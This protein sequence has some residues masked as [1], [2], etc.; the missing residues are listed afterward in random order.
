MNPIDHSYE[1]KQVAELKGEGIKY[2]CID[3]VSMVSEQM[4]NVIAHIARQFAFVFV[5]FGDFKQ[6]EHIDF[7]HSWIVKYVF[8][9][10]MCE[11]TNIHRFDGSKLLQDAHKCANGESIEFNDCT[12][13]EHDLALCI[14]FK[15]RGVRGVI[16]ASFC[17]PG[18]L[19]GVVSATCCKPGWLLG[20]F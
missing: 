15:V 13:E 18:W 20:D 6:V 14:I 12:K 9:N 11:L 3:E 17:K 1:Y 2:I 16:L 10:T 4:W 8:N 19:L 7:K 5:G